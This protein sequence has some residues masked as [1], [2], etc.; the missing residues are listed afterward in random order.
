MLQRKQGRRVP[1]PLLAGAARRGGG[2]GATVVAAERVGPAAVR[3]A[4]TA[5]AA[6]ARKVTVELFA[7]RSADTVQGDGIHT[8][9]Q[10]A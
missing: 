3:R 10:E 7:E 8:R 6:S 2:Q 9:I 5:A 4:A 1:V